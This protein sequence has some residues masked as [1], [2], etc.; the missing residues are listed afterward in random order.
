[1]SPST[2]SM[3]TFLL[4]VTFTLILLA[5][6]TTAL[7]IRHT[8]S[9]TSLGSLFSSFL[10]SAAASAPQL[11]APLSA[12]STISL[13]LAPYQHIVLSPPSPPDFSQPTYP[14]PTPLATAQPYPLSEEPNYSRVCNLGH[15]VSPQREDAAEIAYVGCQGGIVRR[16]REEGEM[17]E[18]LE[19]VACE[20][21][22]WNAVKGEINR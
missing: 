2:T 12:A 17:E 19:C 16:R 5:L 21:G 10:N 7:P 14:H 8:T 1:M 22:T 20:W 9:T 3:P 6:Q 13:S 18:L 15:R 11:Q 4:T